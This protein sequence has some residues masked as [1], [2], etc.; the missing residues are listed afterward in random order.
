[1]TVIAV[2][3]AGLVAALLTWTVARRLPHRAAGTLAA[4]AV[5]AAAAVAPATVGRR[6]WLAARRDPEAATGLALTMA[7]VAIV[8]GV[9][10]LG[11]LA[12]L[13]QGHH[14]VL[15]LD[16]SL[17]DWGR[18]DH[19]SATD[20]ILTAITQLGDTWGIVITCAVLAVVGL[21]RPPRVAVVAV[22]AFVAVVIIGD[23]LA[24]TAVKD[25]VERARPTVNPIAARLGP[26][27]PS[28]HAST[29]AALYAAAA[30][31]LGRGRRRRTR[32]LLA[33][34]GVGLAVV[35]AAT[36]VLL[37]VHWVSDVIGGLA[38]GWAWFAVCVVAFG[39]RLLDFGAPVEDAPSTARTQRLRRPAGERTPRAERS[40]P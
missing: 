15:P 21:R 7:L 14:T 36:R 19:S 3:L 22:V 24:T 35:V 40:V 12:L 10:V 26:A 25:L 9:T 11:L 17:A 20:R 6:S 37:G 30:L 5:E 16:R 31:V 32:E 38:L 8:V 13:L 34:A 39:G 4:E 18:D 28:G 29:A 23:K 27:F 2:I 33:A 1:M